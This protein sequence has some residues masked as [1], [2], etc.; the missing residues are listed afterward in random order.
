MNFDH[1]IFFDKFRPFYKKRTG[2]TLS[3][4]VVNAVDFLLSS[5][6]E[7]THWK[8]IPHISY[9]LATIHHETAFTYEPITEYG[10]KSYFNKYDGRAS[11]GNNQKGDGYRFRGRGY[12]QITGRTNYTKMAKL[13]KV[14]LVNNPELALSRD[15]AFEILTLG[16]HDGLFTGKKLS[17]YLTGS[18]KDYKNARRI[19]NG[20][21]KAA[22]IAAYATE[23]ELMLVEAKA[24]YSA[25]EKVDYETPQEV[26]EV[27]PTDD[28]SSTTIE[29]KDGDIKVESTETSTDKE[30]EKIAIE[31]PEPQGFGT[32][33]RNKIAA[34][35]GGNIGLDFLTEKLSQI[36]ALGLSP[37]FWTK[38]GY[39]VIGGSVIYLIFL[40]YKHHI[41]NKKQL[42][43]TNELIKAN[44]TEN[45]FVQLIATSEIPDYK[46]RGYKVITR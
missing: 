37:E 19:I 29:V 31:K 2:K 14:D 10:G 43:L 7:D 16:M 34:L 33:I 24:N 15:I 30:K 40:A 1:K 13:L 28:S 23:F 9:A 32:T 5:F 45:N 42:E 18:T 36:Q 21:D 46:A 8:S 27:N 44:T 22:Q 17:T 6:E 38:V 20:V 11:L 39:F 3:V 12:V 4:K 26:T 35:T 41:D 25:P